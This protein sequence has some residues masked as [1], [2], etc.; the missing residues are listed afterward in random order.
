M[1]GDRVKAVALSVGGAGRQLIRRRTAAPGSVVLG[2]HDV[3]EH[4]PRPG[5]HDLT[6]TADQ[7]RSHILLLQRLGFSLVSFGRLTADLQGAGG[8]K[9]A[10][11][12]FDDALVG[13]AEVAQPILAEFGVTATVFATTGSPGSPPPWWPGARATLAGERLAELARAGLEIG[14]HTV[15]HRSL[16]TLDDDDLR[17]ELVTSRAWL[18]EVTGQSVDVFAY[19]S[20]HHDDRVR[21]AVVDAGYRAACTFLNGRIT[22]VEDPM[23]LPRLTMGVHS[24][25]RRLAYHLLRPPSSWPSHQI[26]RVGPVTD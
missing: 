26:D 2:Y 10:A 18:R 12:T 21:R 22:G 17:H 1:N 19:P 13:V 9:L 6:V 20:G 14:S 23:R 8:R 3:V 16:I 4:P 7:L 5:G 25:T 15:D 24:T 11:L